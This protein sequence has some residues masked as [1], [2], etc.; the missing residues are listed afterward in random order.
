MVIYN[1]YL[2]L[3]AL[4]S[5]TSGEPTQI[6]PWVGFSFITNTPKQSGSKQFNK[7]S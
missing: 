4:C 2:S 6:M 5:L 7:Y 1:T 3:H